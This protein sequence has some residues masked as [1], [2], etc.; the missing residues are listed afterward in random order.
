MK[1]HDLVQ[2]AASEDTEALCKYYPHVFDAEFPPQNLIH[3][4]LSI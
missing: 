3:D 1:R 2:V 4:V